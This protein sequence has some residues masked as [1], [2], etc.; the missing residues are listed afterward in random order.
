MTTNPNDPA[1]PTPVG[2]S[3]LGLTKREHFAALIFQGFAAAPIDSVPTGDL[4]AVAVKWAE[5]LIAALNAPKRLT[6]QEAT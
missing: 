5:D 2:A 3:Y 1:A 6:K 4:A